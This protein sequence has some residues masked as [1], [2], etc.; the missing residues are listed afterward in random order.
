MGSSSNKFL[1]SPQFLQQAIPR[2]AT[3]R[4][5]AHKDWQTHLA[6][7]NHHGTQLNWHSRWSHCN[8]SCYCWY[9]S[10][11]NCSGGLCCCC[12]SRRYSCRNSRRY[13]CE[14]RRLTSTRLAQLAPSQILIEQVGL[15]ATVKMYRRVLKITTNQP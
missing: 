11:G 13:R 8:W 7:W 15:K 5:Q 4:Q 12:C 6:R 9:C 10:G 1:P 14:S 2:G 3:D